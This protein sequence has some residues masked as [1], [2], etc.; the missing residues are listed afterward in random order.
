MGWFW[1]PMAVV[2]LWQRKVREL[3][4]VR[5]NLQEMGEGR[6]EKGESEVM[7]QKHTARMGEAS[8]SALCP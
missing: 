2:E 4:Q 6:R 7:L 3:S 8:R 1:L 5:N